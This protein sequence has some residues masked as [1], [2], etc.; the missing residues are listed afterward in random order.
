M[1]ALAIVGLV[2]ALVFPQLGRASRRAQLS[3]DRSV[4]VADLR[5]ARAEAARAGHSV[6]LEITADGTGYDSDGQRVRTFQDE[7]VS[8]EPAAVAFFADGSSAGA[9]WIL[10][11]RTGRLAAVVEPGAGLV[12]EAAVR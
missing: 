3:R 6:T 5:R 11:G 4:M 2:S 7:R 9:D 12:R 8:G 1:T 10:T